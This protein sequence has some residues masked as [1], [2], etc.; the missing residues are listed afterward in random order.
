MR[1]TATK[2]SLVLGSAPAGA[3]SV[4]AI[5]EEMRAACDSLVAA[6]GVLVDPAARA[7]ASPPLME[8]YCQG[9]RA[10]L[11]AME[12]LAKHVAEK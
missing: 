8:L 7:G 11:R 2:F 6:L 4:K 5:S 12:D 9:V 3:D 1:D 10:A